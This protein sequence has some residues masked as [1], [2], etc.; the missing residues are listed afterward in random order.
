M[1]MSCGACS[2]VKEALGD[3]GAGA[4]GNRVAQEISAE[5]VALLNADPPLQLGFN[6]FGFFAFVF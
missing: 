6:F 4:V 1:H 5:P 2:S 3:P